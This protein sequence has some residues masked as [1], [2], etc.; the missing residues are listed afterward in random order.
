MELTAGALNMQFLSDRNT[1][2]TSVKQA[3][4]TG[5]VGTCEVS[6]ATGSRQRFRALQTST[7][8]NLVTI[9]VER[10]YDFAQS[11]ASQGVSTLVSNG[12]QSLGMSVASSTYT[13]LAMQ[14]VTTVLGSAKSST[15]DD[16][17]GD[18]GDLASKFS[19]AL[20]SVDLS[21][22][23][24]LTVTPP[25]PPPIAPPS[26]P[27][28]IPPTPPA[29]PRAATTY[30]SETEM[31]AYIIGL[32]VAGGVLV[33]IVICGA[34]MI[35]RNNSVLHMHP[36]ASAKI[37]PRS[38]YTAPPGQRE[39]SKSKVSAVVQGPEHPTSTT[40]GDG[41]GAVQVTSLA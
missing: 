29:L 11:E 23:A 22:S 24:P 19:S 15:L 40:H 27:P 5:L 28:P 39:G 4:C 16:N 12:L 38:E 34:L 36:M 9:D 7:S 41:A 1:L 26:P 10:R 20:P 25:R 35:H 21:V 30:G 2:L 37:L 3:A 14:S 33:A 8:A 6:L 18:Q 32:A 17:F 31:P 13:K